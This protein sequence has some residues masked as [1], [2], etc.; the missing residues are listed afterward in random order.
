M[1]RRLEIILFFLTVFLSG[2]SQVTFVLEHLP[3]ATPPADSVF[4]SGTFNNWEMS[5]KYV[6][7]KRLDGKLAVTLPG[8]LGNFEYK[9]TRGTWAK[10]ETDE[11]NAFLPN[12]RYEGKNKVVAV[13]ILNWQDVGGAKPPSFFV[14]YF[15][16]IAFV[17]LVTRHFLVRLK[18]PN[19]SL[20]NSALEFQILISI[21]LLGRVALEVL[22]LEWTHYFV[23]GGQ[24]I[25]MLCCVSLL[26]IA[27]RSTGGRSITTTQFIPTCIL[28]I[29]MVLK[30]INIPVL[31]FLNNPATYAL[32]WDD[33][34]VDAFIVGNLVWYGSRMVRLVVRYKSE[35]PVMSSFLK[36]NVILGG[37][38][39][40]AFSITVVGDLIGKESLVGSY[41]SLPFFGSLF[42]V[43]MC[44][45][46]LNR[47]E[48][49]RLM[50]GEFRQDEFQQLAKSIDKLMRSEK[51]YLNPNLTLN[52]LAECVG[53][54]PHALSRIL[55]DGH[56]LKFRDFV[57]SYRVGE[58]I[59]LAT[60]E[61][62]KRYTYLALA[63][64]VGFNS[65][66]TFN[67]AFKKNTEMSP[68]EYFQQLKGNSLSDRDMKSTTL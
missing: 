65:K 35:S 19:R 27:A 63:Y 9:F 45:F 54:K 7:K 17:V 42:I 12:R 57:N 11:N 29:Y 64:E 30:I 16:T 20:I 8:G 40:L 24:L 15:F 55:N 36:M 1:S 25:L 47:N 33:V 67:A 68:R 31:M 10:A 38:F 48:V 51:L 3:H 49:F 21:A 28:L 44:W 41:N 13:S 2:Q 37:I 4:I 23:Y 60:L 18:S 26:D 59:R 62:S 34:I 32:T 46:A 61:S 58:F 6:F 43:E 22:P 14:F 56:S 53:L 52:E 50:P 5:P 39:T 66:S